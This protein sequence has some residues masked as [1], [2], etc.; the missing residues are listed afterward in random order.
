[1]HWEEGEIESDQHQPEGNVSQALGELPAGRERKEIVE[2]R[3][4]RKDRAA[5]QHRV[6]MTD[7]EVRVVRLQ[8]ERG[9][10]HHD[11]GQSA[12]HERRE[13]ADDKQD[14]NRA[15]YPAHQ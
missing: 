14:R 6:E 3:D 4:D 5:N 12:K 13:P 15:N 2:A 1:V 10:G 7:D 11:A 9:H 8:V